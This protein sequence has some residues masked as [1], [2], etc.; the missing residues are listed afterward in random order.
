MSNSAQRIASFLKWQLVPV[1]YLGRLR[2]L[3]PR[4]ITPANS[5]RSAKGMEI[6]AAGYAAGPVLSQ[7][8]L[9][10]M[11][12]IFVSRA[13]TAAPEKLKAPFINLSRAEDLTKDNPLVQLAFSKDILDVA[14]DYFGGRLTLDSLQ[15]LHSFPQT[16]PL[17]ESQKWHLDY[18]DSRSLH[19]VYYL[20]DV[21]DMDG[22]PFVFI[23]KENSKKV[24]R[25]LIV[26]RIE[27]DQFTQESN[28]APLQIAYGKAGTSLWVDPAACYH[29]GSRCKRP[30]TAIF[31]TFNSDS[32]F[33][34]PTPLIV[35]NARQIAEAGKALRPDLDPTVIDKMLRL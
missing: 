22:G 20:N 33:M 3:R 24:G 16:G 35:E 21:T 18:G 30:R 34:A 26:R 12:E 32:P 5:P 28:D 1:R 2:Y 14:I 27:D 4:H 8:M 19:C 9:T 15:V 25:G 17:K 13:P 23:D 6:E 31:L 29:Y 11:Q 10:K 7:D